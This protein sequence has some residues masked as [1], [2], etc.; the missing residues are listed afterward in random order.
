MLE[1]L[2]RIKEEGLDP[3]QKRTIAIL[4]AVVVVVGGIVGYKMKDYTDNDPNFCNTCHLMDDAFD[5]WAESAH[6]GVNCHDCHHL[7]FKEQNMLLINLVL[8]NPKEVAK[9]NPPTRHG[10][11][12]VP[13]EKC[14]GCHWET[15]EKYPT[16]PKVNASPIHAKHY[17]MEQIPCSRCHGSKNIHQF[18]VDPQFCADCHT[19]KTKIHGVEAAASGRDLPMMDLACLNCHTDAKM[20]LMPTRDKCLSCHGSDAQR[21]RISKLP[22]TGDTVAFALNPKDI[23]DAA[24]NAPTVFPEGAPMQFDCSRC[25]NPHDKMKLEGNNDCLV[26][27]SKQTK[28]GMHGFHVNDMG[29]MCIDCHKPHSWNAT[30]EVC[31]DCHGK[32]RSIA[33]F[34][35]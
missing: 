16:A 15:S 28:I 23:A 12:I 30:S 18:K 31:A 4:L 14:V 27:H 8:H 10:H 5:R 33:K 25:H 20:D 13:D 9:R 1:F 19:D 26:C 3:K 24:K 7:S 6:S 29:A 21:D 11:I 34:L 35:D 22:A 2:K 17:F 32:P